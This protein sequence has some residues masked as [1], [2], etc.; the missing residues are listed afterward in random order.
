MK[1]QLE[2]KSNIE[3]E[4]TETLNILKETRDMFREEPKQDI[5]AA[6]DDL[7]KTKR[8]ELGNLDI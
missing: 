2:E 8:L 7:M 1:E 3:D 4:N 5:D 6:L